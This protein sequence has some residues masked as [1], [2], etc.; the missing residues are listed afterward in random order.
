MKIILAKNGQKGN[1][2]YCKANFY[3]YLPKTSA[4]DLLSI[5]Y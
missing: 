3:W 1:L 5:F 4:T 2:K